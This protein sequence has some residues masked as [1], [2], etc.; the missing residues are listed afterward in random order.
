M[1]F[2]TWTNTKLVKWCQVGVI[3][4]RHE[5]AHCSHSYWVELIGQF[6]LSCRSIKNIVQ[7]FLEPRE[8]PRWKYICLVISEAILEAADHLLWQFGRMKRLFT[9]VTLTDLVSSK[10]M[11][12]KLS[13]ACFASR[14]RSLW[15]DQLQFSIFLNERFHICNCPT[16]ALTEN[17]SNICRILDGPQ[18]NTRDFMGLFL[19][20]FQPFSHCQ[21]NKTC[22]HLYPTGRLTLVERFLKNVEI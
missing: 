18:V 6:W 21:Y 5:A 11:K 13:F 10:E 8:N 22:K 19:W 20:G 7:H 4:C 3:A 9:A 15:V 1:H 2:L 17:S 14:F 12:Q 16:S